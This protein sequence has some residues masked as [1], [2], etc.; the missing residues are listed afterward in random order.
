VLK[1]LIATS[2]LIKENNMRKVY[3]LEQHLMM[4]LVEDKLCF[5]DGDWERL[6]RIRLAID[7]T[8]DQIAKLE[9]TV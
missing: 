8:R 9:V 5:E 3:E 6:D 1:T 2:K 4:L 7:D